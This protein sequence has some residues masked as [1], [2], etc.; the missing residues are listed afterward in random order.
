MNT[1]TK[2]KLQELYNLQP[3]SKLIKGHGGERFSQ[4]G[5]K[6]VETFKLIADL[7]PDDTVLDVGC[8]PGRMALALAPYLGEKGRYEGFDIKPKDIAWCKQEIEPRWSR[9]RFQLVDIKNEHYNP[10]GIISADKFKFPYEDNTFDFVFLTSVFTHLLPADLSNYLREVSRV[11]KLGGR[12]LISYFLLNESI[13]DSIQAK[14]ARFNFADNPQPHCY[15]EKPENPEDVVA[16]DEEFIR[17][18]YSE[19]GLNIKEPIYFGS[20]SGTNSNIKARHGQDI[21]LA[22]KSNNKEIIKEKQLPA[23]GF[24]EHQNQIRFVDFISDDDLNE[25]NNILKWN[26]FVVDSNGRRFGNQAWQGKRSTPQIIPDKRIMLMNEYFSLADKDVLEVGCF[27]GIHTIGLS[28]YANKVTAIDSRIENVVKT[29][30]RCSLFGY[31]PNVFKLDVE[32]DLS[33]YW[34]LLTADV[35]HHVGVLYHLKDPITHLL[36]LGKY[37]RRGIMLDTHYALEE[38]AKEVCEVAGRQY[39]YKK[40]REK[41]YQD[42]FSGMY[43][44]SKWLKLDDIVSLLNESGFNKI[45]I[46]E[47]RDERN[48]P[49]VLLM[50]KK[51]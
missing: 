20:W 43:D 5:H 40:Y 22:V 23:N 47:K 3:P 19:I 1:T 28:Q 31:Q 8:G 21:I 35:M 9:S 36:E 7:K 24:K 39:Y 45:D 13:R 49:R 44:Y 50:A 12:C 15:I 33:N 30:V 11:L 26:C 32:Q 27:E 37:I 48:G 42:V 38:E 14:K 46:I 29:I 18:Q 10:D 4:L 16:Y 6:W 25:L 17:N 41:G 51:S 2:D 34:D